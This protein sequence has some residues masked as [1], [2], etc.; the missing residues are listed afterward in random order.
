MLFLGITQYDIKVFIY[1]VLKTRH[2]IA[3]QD[4]KAHD[5]V[6]QGTAADGRPSGARHAGCARLVQLCNH[7]QVLQLLWVEIRANIQNSKS[8]YS[9]YLCK[10]IHI[11][12]QR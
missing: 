10:S 6:D 1:T 7:T 5:V 8:Q 3:V 11:L 4:A 2:S 9:L 12:S